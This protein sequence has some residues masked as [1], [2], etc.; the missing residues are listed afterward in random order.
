MMDFVQSTS[1]VLACSLAP[2]SHLSH[3]CFVD[4]KIVVIDRRLLPTF[5][6]PACDNVLIQNQKSGRE[7]LSLLVDVLPFSK[8]PGFHKEKMSP[9]SF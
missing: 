8:M 6:L 4:S 7:S 9:R 3:N 5:F 2:S 1:G